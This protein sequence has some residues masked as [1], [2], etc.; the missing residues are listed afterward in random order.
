MADEQITSNTANIPYVNLINVGSDQAA[1]SAGRA[2][3]YIKEG[4]AYVR[5]DTGAPVAI[6]GA[7]ALPEGRLAIGDGS[8]VLSALALGTEGQLVTADA[9]GFATWAAA[10]TGE[11][12]GGLTQIAT[13][14]V[15]AGGEASYN[16]A[17]IPQTYKHL[18][19]DVYARSDRSGQDRD[20]LMIQLN[21]R[22]TDDGYSK[23][24]WNYQTGVFLD[25]GTGYD[26]RLFIGWLPGATATAGL[27]S[28]TRAVFP[29]YTST[30]FTRQGYASGTMA[31]GTLA[32]QSG[33]THAGWLLPITAAITSILVFTQYAA[34]LVEGSILTL[35]GGD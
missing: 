6:G 3:L 23:T 30:K 8:G 28:F 26:D 13:H 10:P 34:N 11:G 22:T 7:V 31:I 15:G 17:D 1:P 27:G 25:N 14:T 19:L 21:G 20:Y 33:K 35:Y 2:I 32:N 29:M 12:G 24:I 16:F 18:Y 5:L 9:S 4:V